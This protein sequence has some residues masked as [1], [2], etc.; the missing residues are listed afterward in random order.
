MTTKADF[1]NVLVEK[2]KSPVQLCVVLETFFQL[3]GS[4]TELGKTYNLAR[5]YKTGED[6]LP[7]HFPHEN[8]SYLPTAGVLWRLMCLPKT[9]NL[10]RAILYTFYNDKVERARFID[11]LIDEPVREHAIKRALFW[12]R[13]EMVDILVE[14][15]GDI[16]VQD[17]STNLTSYEHALYY[18][19]KKV[20]EY[21]S[22]KECV[23][24]STE[25][26]VAFAE[27]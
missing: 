10:V 24:K 25:R 18:K 7:D 8:T 15:G 4:L 14:A 5:L 19:N 23:N 27:K 6:K 12:C 13:F 20:L 17:C 16:N 11:Q 22:K 1:V 3:D 2:C 26:L 9:E 21:L